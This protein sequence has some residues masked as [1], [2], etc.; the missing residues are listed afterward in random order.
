MKTTTA[1]KGL[2]AGFTALVIATTSVGNVFASR[3]DYTN[4][5]NT[6]IEHPR[7]NFYY[8]V[9]NGVGDEADFV[10][11]R[12]NNGDVKA[13]VNVNPLTDTLAAACTVG[14][15]FDVNTYVHN[16]AND[17]FN[18]NGTGSAVAHNV[19]VAMRAELGVAKKN[20][21]FTS[22]ISGESTT[23]GITVASVTDTGKL[24]CANNV[25]LKLVPSSVNVY[26]S[27]VG[28]KT[29]PTPDSVVNG[30]LRVGSRVHD[31]G[32]VWGCWNDRVLVRYTVEVEKLPETPPETPKTPPVTVI[33]QTGAGAMVGS[34]AGLSAV[35]YSAT[36]LINKRRALKNLK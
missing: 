32:D 8:N 29:T 3:V 33:P 20:F 1:I 23:P 11:V 22:T 15:K 26:N 34:A 9:P 7:F 27:P 28:W 6:A 5:N 13:A 10:K 17:D 4:P 14:E 35:A 12:K 21:V 36:A 2:V 19:M 31:S 30:S 25:R 18:N 16:G 24:N